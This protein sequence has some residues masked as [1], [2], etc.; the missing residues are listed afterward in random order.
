MNGDEE[1]EKF[2]A[3]FRK[4]FSRKL[5]GT[6]RTRRDYLNNEILKRQEDLGFRPSKYPWEK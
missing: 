1:L 5:T 3:D 4:I 6:I 2:S